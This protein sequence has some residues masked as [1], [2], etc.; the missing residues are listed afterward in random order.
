[1][2]F[3]DFEDAA[4]LS[5]ARFV[6]MRGAVARLH[7]ALI[8]FMLNLHVEQHGHEELY[9]PYLVKGEVLEG[10]GQLPKFG[11]DLFAVDGDD[12]FFLTRPLSHPC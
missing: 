1:M 10:T 7:R 6:V 12:G 5:G 2:G 3:L 9:V 8:Q 11:E 4:K